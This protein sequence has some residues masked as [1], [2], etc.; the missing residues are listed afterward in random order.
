LLPPTPARV[1]FVGIGGIGMSGLARILNAW[2]Y[3]V[4]GS[5]AAASPLLEELKGEGIAV[6]IGHSATDAATAADLVVATAAVRPDNPEIAAALAAG[7]PLVKR[8]RLLGALADARRGVAVA[9]SHGKSTTSGMIAAALRALG[10]DPSFAIGAVLAGAGTN[11]APGAGEEM[12]VEADEYDWSFLHLHPHVALITNVE[13]DH[14][15]LFPDTDAYDAAFAT[16]IAGMRPDGTLVIAADDPGCARLM[17]RHDWSPP[18]S[19]VTFGESADASWRLERTEEGWRVTGPDDIAVPL[20]LGAGVSG[21]HNARNATAA[22]AAL[23]S[24]GYDAATAAAALES[25]RGVGRR[26]ETKGEARGVLVID[27]YAHHPSEIAVNLRTAKERFPDRRLWAVFQPHTF[28]RLKALLSDFAASFVEADRVMI[29]DVYA[30]RETDDLGIASADLVKLLPAGTLT[31]RDP[32]DAARLLAEAVAAGDVVLTLGAGSI[33]DTG[34]LL[35]NLLQVHGQATAPQD[36]SALP[37][38]RTADVGNSAGGGGLKRATQASP[39]QAPA[40]TELQQRLTS[41]SGRPHR[42]VAGADAITIPGAPG[43][44]VLRGAPMRLHTTWRIGGPADFLVRAATPDDLIAAV[45]WAKQEGLPVTVIGGGSNLLVDDEGIRGLVVLARTP[46][47]RALDLVEVE[48][49][50]DA[51]RL[52]VAAQAP[53]SWT[54]RFAAE[55]GWTGMD[56]GVGLPGTIG[57]ATVNNAGAHGTE[58]I[59]HLEAVVILNERG[60]IE[61]RPAAWLEAAYRHTI[62][63]AAPRPRPWTVLAAVM[64][65][66]KGDPATLVRLADE[67]A[68]FR[69]ET[70]PTGA[71]AGSTFANPPGDFAG[72]L[73]EESGLKGFAVGGAAFSPKHANWIVNDGTATAADVRALIATA[74]ARVRDRFGVELRREVEYLQLAAHGNAQVGEE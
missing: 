64:L 7:R 24:L 37:G 2:G 3:T 22:L 10:A 13:Y 41:H 12:V 32:A 66:P 4:S 44:K 50:G 29:L 26:F 62:I 35:L 9:G 27:D 68:A 18:R 65:L 61:E 70:Q 21:R 63:K 72:R 16:F 71:C 67:H 42:G 47:E 30:A 23:V 5:D 38:G 57:G 46:G 60:D 6:T 39:L 52:R 74:Q 11:A 69:K 31:A 25:F 28:S 8:A 1:H 49:L 56:W 15:D 55:R 58:Q 51:V 20:S 17:V 54:G 73:L 43:L 59:D 19:V 48:D 53:L 14:P 40:T 34:P 45:S 33:T 36:Q